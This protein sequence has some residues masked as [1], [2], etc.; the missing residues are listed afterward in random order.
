MHLM[1]YASAAIAKVTRISGPGRHI[2]GKNVVGVTV[3]VL[4]G[5]VVAHRGPG[6]SVP[7][8][9]LDIAQVHPG[10]QHG[11]HVCLSI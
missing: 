4:A 10:I 11:R 9:D 8:S 7:G 3:E 5:P 2:G 6:I 1:L